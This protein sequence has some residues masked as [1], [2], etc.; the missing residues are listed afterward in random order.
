MIGQAHFNEG[1]TRKKEAFAGI[2][3]QTYRRCRQHRAV[4]EAVA[5]YS[6]GHIQASVTDLGYFSSV[7]M[8]SVRFLEY[9]QLIGVIYSGEM[10]AG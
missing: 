5:S 8:T 7:F 2:K 9:L 3:I 6:M 1:S 4:S 10:M